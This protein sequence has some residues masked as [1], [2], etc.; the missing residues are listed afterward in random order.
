MFRQATILTTALTLFSICSL[1]QQ[2]NPFPTQR[3]QP[4]SMRDTATSFSGTV[5]SADDHP[6]KDV[7]VELRQVENGQVV[8]SVY[9]NAS[10]AFE[11]SHVTLGTY[12]VVATY[13]LEETRDRVD[14]SGMGAMSNLRMPVST[15]ATDGNNR[16]TVSVAQY[17]VPEKAREELKK[18]QA[19]SEK[20]R[21][22]E[23]QK[24]IAKA[25]EIYPK[26]ADALTLRGVLKLDNHDQ[27]GAMADLQQAIQYDGNSPMA[28]MVMGAVLNMQSKFDD[29]IR[30]L[31][32]GE[33]LS[34]NSWQS[35]FEMGKSLVGKQQ[36][37]AALRQLDRAQA[38]TPKD[39]PLIHLVKAHALLAMTNY[40][41]AMTELQAYLDK[42][43]KGPNSEQAQKMLAQAKAF[44]VKTT[45]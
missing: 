32:H 37:E 5:R 45:K 9:T 17:K 26:Y 1:A 44:S 2:I 20:Q 4:M 22:D 42:E 3:N 7:R 35:Y 25:L 39:Y 14:I 31:Q 11:F 36:Y 8:A 40:S 29:A 24:H 19:A 23:A 21:T 30:A 43:P 12:D 18:A 28:Y 38:L 27:E 34:P 10:G 41:D 6:L 15:A 33:A 16:N 13:Q